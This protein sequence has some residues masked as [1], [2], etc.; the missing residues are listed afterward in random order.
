MA[1]TTYLVSMFLAMAAM[2]SGCTNA[3]EAVKPSVLLLVDNL[4]SYDVAIQS[5][6]KAENDYYNGLQRT[7]KEAAGRAAIVDEGNLRIAAIDSYVDDLLLQ[8]NAASGTNAVSVTSLKRFLLE[9]D[10][11]LNAII[12]AQRVAEAEAEAA[13]VASFRKIR[14]KTTEIKN[15]KGSLLQAIREPSVTEQI[16]WW[17]AYAKEVQK[18]YEALNQSN[19]SQPGNGG[20]GNN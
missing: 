17:V 1:Q 4:D 14:S 2:L 7:L 18:Q 10:E 6:A 11:Q 9:T 20:Q 5:F 12:A 8:S 3:H 16:D 19:D 15:L 13:A